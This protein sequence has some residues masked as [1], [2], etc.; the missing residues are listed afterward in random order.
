MFAFYLL[1]WCIGIGFNAIA[2]LLVFRF[3]FEANSGPVLASMC[4]TRICLIGMPIFAF[5][6]GIGGKLPGT[7]RISN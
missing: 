3:H 4:M 2:I 5:I 6:L 1:G 7:R